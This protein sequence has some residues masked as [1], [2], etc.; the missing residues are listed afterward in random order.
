M[1]N[2]WHYAYIC[3]WLIAV[4]LEKKAIIDNKC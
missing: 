2:A 1:M 4:E 3:Q